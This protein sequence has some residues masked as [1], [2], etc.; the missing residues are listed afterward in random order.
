VPVTFRP[1]ADSVHSF[2]LFGFLP[3]AVRAV[4]EFGAFARTVL[5]G[6]RRD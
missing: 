2:V 4:A 5:A 6:R 3:E 1:V